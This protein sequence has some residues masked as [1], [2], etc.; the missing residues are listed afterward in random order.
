MRKKKIRMD[1][2]KKKKETVNER[3][4]WIRKMVKEKS[5]MLIVSIVLHLQYLRLQFYMNQKLCCFIQF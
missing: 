1:E 5:S 2:N 4:E 3:K